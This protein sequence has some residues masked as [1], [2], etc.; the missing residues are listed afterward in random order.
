MTDQELHYIHHEMEALSIEDKD[1]L[2]SKTRQLSNLILGQVRTQASG[3]Q[4]QMEQGELSFADGSRPDVFDQQC[5][6]LAN[7]LIETPRF[8]SI[9]ITGRKDAETKLRMMLNGD[10][11]RQINRKLSLPATSIKNE[12]Q[13]GI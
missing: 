6:M 7:Q 11:A 5:S 1:F 3:G 2:R 9:R 10:T 13:G 8:G 4:E 12:Q